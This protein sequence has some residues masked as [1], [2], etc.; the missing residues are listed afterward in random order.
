MQEIGKFE[1][2]LLCLMGGLLPKD[3][4]QFEIKLLEERVGPNWFSDLGY[5]EPEF[6]RPK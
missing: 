5:T 2:L 6:E 1:N 3:L 4:S